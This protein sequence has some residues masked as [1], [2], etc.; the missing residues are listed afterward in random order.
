MSEEEFDA[1]CDLFAEA[2]LRYENRRPLPEK[3]GDLPAA[4]GQNGTNQVD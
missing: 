2:I 3:S 4:V 1:L